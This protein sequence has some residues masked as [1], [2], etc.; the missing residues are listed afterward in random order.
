MEELEFII[1]LT[2]H[3]FLGKVFQPFLIRKR[4]KFYSV[5][6]LLKPHDFDTGDYTW[7]PY[8]KELVKIIER[9]SDERLVKRFSRSG[10]VASFYS[11][12]DTG[13]YEQQVVPFMENAM[14][15]VVSILMLSPVRLFLKEAQYS[16]LYDEDVVEVPP[17]FARP[18]FHFERTEMQTRYK[19]KLFLE[20]RELLISERTCTIIANDPC[21]LLY[22]RQLLAFEKLNA[23]KLLPFFEKDFVSVPNTIEDKYY[24]GFILKTIRDFDVKATGFTI[25]EE[26][27]ERSA[28]LSLETNLQAQPALVL[29]FNYG[30]E[31]FLPNAKKQTAVSFRKVEKS[32]EFYKTR[33]DQ[34]WEE[35]VLRR[36][37]KIGLLEDNGA[38]SL[39]GME[40][41]ELQNALYFL[42]DWLSRHRAELE[43]SGIRLKQENT[44]KKYFTGSRE[45]E[46]KAQTKGD[47][48]DVF[49]V[50][51]FG[52]FQIPFIK[53]KKYILNNI[54]EFEL[55]N[56]EIAVLPDE[57]FARYKGL[58]PFGKDHG[59][60]IRFEKHHF[61]LLQESVQEID[62]E[63]KQKY[64]ELLNTEK[65]DL[66][67]PAKLKAR[68]RG[69]QEGGFQWM[70]G[71]Y[72]NGMGACLADDMGLGK[73]LQT[74]TLLLKL[75]RKAQGITISDPLDNSGQLDMFAIDK[76]AETP[77]QPAS[78]IVVPT[79]LVHNWHAEIEKFTPS[80]KAFIYFGTQRKKV[81]DIHKILG[82]YDVIITTYGTVRN[83][84]EM[85][86]GKEF[87][88]L[89]LDESQS[90]KNPG[91]KT[92][93]ALMCMKARH[94]LVIT[95]TPIEN[96]L[97]DLWSQMNFLNPGLLGSLAFFKRS[98]ITPI[99]KH[100]N[101][102]QQQK[103]QLMIRP[104]VLRR[105]KSE[106]ASDLPPLMEEVR[107]CPMVGG[108]QRMYDKEKSVIRNTILS[109]IEK[110]GMNKSQFVVLQGLTR[111]RQLAN[112]PSLFEQVADESSGKYDEVFRMLRN[113]VA[114]KHKVLIFSSFVTHLELIEGGIK[115]E[116]WSY[117]KLTGKTT[118]RKQVISNF[119]D[120]EENRIFLIS[121][122]AGG[123]GLNLTEADYV[124]ILDP[125]WNPAAEN[126]AIN[127]AH[128]IGQDKH[129]FVYRF[130]TE[131][132]IEEKIQKLKERKSSL[133]DKFINSN[134]PFEQIS[135]EEIVDLFR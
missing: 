92:Y 132:S 69:Y 108:Q 35:K 123:V 84:L 9:Y 18:E 94:K 60:K 127:R 83:D 65:E 87:F 15:E 48:F 98:F 43:R 133:A 77:D 49:A 47:W 134:D 28:E 52:E 38:F 40:V 13:V 114:E 23:R 21:L 62:K 63:V 116:K 119:Q 73:T 103:L 112:H 8:E 7:N 12:I 71:L 115:K 16:N 120:D 79:S 99:E 64:L 33:R 110:D 58:L 39:K 89:I 135:K 88:Y 2:D 42:L 59:K 126:Q 113:L 24:S 22:R 6:R 54:K 20:E 36:L 82:Y 109:T 68:L 53:L 1:A 128:R 67:V 81:E 122:K 100:A 121:L 85:M 25:R 17:V 56:G 61:T 10:S 131:N 50:V 86:E 4:E 107:I 96:S 101:E 30:Q 78:L 130:I 32:F 74:L 70:Y 117:S 97:S 11:S 66:V 95:G 90:I 51:R 5:V 27:L 104:F 102:E 45:L 80:L 44:G 14:M 91:S 41:L 111:L 57:W 31:S 3:R 125:W 76:E 75:K 129:V 26:Q 105:T 55:P 46:I 37:K 29:R 19:L 34:A 124:F 93:K 118:N 106:V 72:K